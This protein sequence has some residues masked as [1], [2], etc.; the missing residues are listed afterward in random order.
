MTLGRREGGTW[1][2]EGA[3][4]STG[5]GGVKSAAVAATYRLAKR[6]GMAGNRGRVGAA[7]TGGR[8]QRCFE[9]NT[10]RRSQGVTEPRR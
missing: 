3:V 10:V 8:G 9:T 1:K 6:S 2:R 4:W 7:R 5:A